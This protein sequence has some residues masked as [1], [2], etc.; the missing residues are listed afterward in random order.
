[1]ANNL[2]IQWQ[3]VGQTIA[4]IQN[5]LNAL[6]ASVLPAISAAVAGQ[7]PLVNAAGTGYVLVNLSGRP[8]ASA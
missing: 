1:V 3:G 8:P 2:L 7:F 4:N 6:S 5:Q